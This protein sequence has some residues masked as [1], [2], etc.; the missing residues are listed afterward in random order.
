[1]LLGYLDDEPKEMDISGL[2]ET[3]IQSRRVKEPGG[4][5]DYNSR[6]YGRRE[7]QYELSLRI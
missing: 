7:Y 3:W 2:S 1:M 6:I 4:C 5:L